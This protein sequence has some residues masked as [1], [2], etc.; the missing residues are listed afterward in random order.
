MSGCPG[1]AHEWVSRTGPLHINGRNSRQ[2]G[3]VPNSGLYIVEI[4][5]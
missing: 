4:A 3:D 2:F 1:P 5:A